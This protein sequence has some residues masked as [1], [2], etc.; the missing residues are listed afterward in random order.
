VAMRLRS[1]SFL[2]CV[3]AACS[4]GGG[5]GTAGGSGMA[6]S[7]TAGGTGGMAGGSALAGGSGGG[8]T[9]VTL[10]SLSLAPAAVTLAATETQQLTATGHYSDGSM[11]DVTQQAAWSSTVPGVAAV[12]STG[13]VT[14]AIDGMTDV[15]ATLEGKTATRTVTVSGVALMSIAVTPEMI[16]LGVGEQLQ[17]VATG[18]Y[19]DGSKRNVSA[20]VAWT[21]SAP[22]VATVSVTGLVAAMTTGTTT[23]EAVLRGKRSSVMASV[24]AKTVSALVIS[25]AALV[26]A[27]GE[28][29]QLTATATYSDGTTGD[30][31]STAT[32]EVLGSSPPVSVSPTGLFTATMANSGRRVR[33]VAGG[34][35]ALASTYVTNTGF[36]LAGLVYRAQTMLRG[37]TTNPHWPDADF[38]GVG[39]TNFVTVEWTTSDPTVV[40]IL[41]TGQWKAKKVGTSMMTAR[42]YTAMGMLSTTGPATVTE[43]VPDA[44]TVSSGASGTATLAQGATLQLTATGTSSFFPQLNA[45]LTA[46]VTWTSSNPGAVTV[47]AAGLARGVGQG[48]S[49]IT[50][51]LGST[52]GTTMVTVPVTAPPEQTLTLSPTDDNSVLISS[53]NASAET[54]VYPTNALFQGPGLAVG[55]TWFWNPPIGP[56][57]ERFDALCGKALIKFDLSPLAGKTVISA[58]LRLTTAAH[59]VGSVPRRWAIWALASPWSGSSVTWSSASTFQHYVY[60]E[61][62]HD[63]P[64]FTSQAYDLDQ[65]QT[66]RNWVSGAYQ[67][68]GWELGITNY[69]YPYVRYSSFDAFELCSKEDTRGCGPRLVVTYR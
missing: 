58:R 4:G 52:Q 13:L 33:A 22:A 31:T 28:T 1:A 18:T 32:W 63:P 46:Q 26:L 16:Q 8:S 42:T 5:G 62:Q 10:E 2:V 20:E 19:A 15:T 49:T 3:L 45:D 30:V 11:R 14:A 66:V 43:P 50:A 48:T 59:G 34:V 64:T 57:P 44:I 65:T 27:P 24:V 41:P 9:A 69:L 7:G 21:S 68:Q 60:S 36:P 39:S 56:A 12:S 53:I 6:G 25:P 35:E 17:F 38:G 54:T 47:D 67:N 61:T 23:V 55:C 29:K 37:V 51:A 40:E